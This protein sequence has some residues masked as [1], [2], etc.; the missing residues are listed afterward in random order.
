M[1]LKKKDTIQL[2]LSFK[3]KKGN[4][5]DLSG[6]TVRI[7]SYNLYDYSELF[8]KGVTSFSGDENNTC[9]FTF[10]YSL[11]PASGFLCCITGT[12]R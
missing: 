4:A 9:V 8:N 1:R 3:D 7:I 11:L 2:I 10:P 12:Y 6:H 5:I